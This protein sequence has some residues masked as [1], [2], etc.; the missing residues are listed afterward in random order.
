MIKPRNSLLFV[1]CR[2][3]YGGAKISWHSSLTGPIDLLHF[4]N[5]NFNPSKHNGV[6]TK[7]LCLIHELQLFE[8]RGAESYV[9]NYYKRKTNLM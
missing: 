9:V 7:S 3:F 6:N 1:G 4:T 5:P 2:I 8:P